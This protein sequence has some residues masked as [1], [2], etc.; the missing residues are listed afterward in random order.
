[1]DREAD[2]ARQAKLDTAVSIVTA[3][4]AELDELALQFDEE[5][6]QLDE[7]Y[8]AQ[9]EELKEVIVRARTTGIDVRYI[10]IGWLPGA[11]AG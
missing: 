6:A 10:G 1:M 9:T 7:A 11:V 3:V 4:Q 8:D 2:Q 5:V